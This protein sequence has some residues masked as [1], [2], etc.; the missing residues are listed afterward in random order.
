MKAKIV[1]CDDESNILPDSS[2]T[3]Y[4]F[5]LGGQSL[6]V[7]EQEVEQFRYQVLP[8]LEANLL[9]SAQ[10]QK[11]YQLKKQDRLSSAAKNE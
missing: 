6:D 8:E 10:E 7:I 2:S 9:K 5:K 1:L 3:A 11:T 4:S